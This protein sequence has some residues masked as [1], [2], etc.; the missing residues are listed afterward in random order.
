MSS[1]MKQLTLG[2]MLLI[3]ATLGGCD[4]LMSRRRSRDHQRVLISLTV[5]DQSVPS[6]QYA[7]LSRITPTKQAKE[8]GKR[9]R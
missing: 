1:A 4:A 6:S 5:T 9:S 3:S 7:A 2:L 8:I